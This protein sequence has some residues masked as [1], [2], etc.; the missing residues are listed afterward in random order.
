MTKAAKVAN[1]AAFEPMKEVQK[2]TADQ[3]LTNVGVLP[4]L[5]HPATGV[6]MP[7]KV[8]Q[9]KMYPED[10][11]GWQGEYFVTPVF[12]E[13]RPVYAMPGGGEYRA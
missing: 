4:Y 8:T 12:H 13:G 7:V 6:W 9:E 1:T 11:S 5:Q 10:G 2:T 3:V